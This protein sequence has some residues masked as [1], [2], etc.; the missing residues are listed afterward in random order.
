MSDKEFTARMI[1]MGYVQDP[2]SDGNTWMTK[3]LFDLTYKK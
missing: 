3:E 2:K 1:A